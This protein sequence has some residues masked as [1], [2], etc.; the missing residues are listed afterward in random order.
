ME[1]R[2]ALAP[3]VSVEIHTYGIL[4]MQR[5]TKKHTCLL[6]CGCKQLHK[7]GRLLIDV[8]TYA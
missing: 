3:S 8:A 6:T 5:K 2:H 7:A 1:P 4:N